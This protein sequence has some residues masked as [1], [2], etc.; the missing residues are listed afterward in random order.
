MKLFQNKL[1]FFPTYRKGSSYLA[2]LV[3]ENPLHLILLNL[4]TYMVLTTIV[5]E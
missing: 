3:C 1:L 5:T 4:S 2:P